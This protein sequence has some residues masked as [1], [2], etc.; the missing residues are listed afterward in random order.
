MK[1]KPLTKEV[2]LF[3]SVLSVLVL[4]GMTFTIFIIVDTRDCG[5]VDSDINEDII[6]FDKAS[7][8]RWMSSSCEM[9][10]RRFD[11]KFYY[12]GEKDDVLYGV[13]SVKPFF[14]KKMTKFMTMRYNETNSEIVVKTECLVP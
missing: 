2:L 5:D 4:T 12:I 7:E 9:P 13:C 8:I 11:G 3:M 10:T 1:K 6:G 14:H